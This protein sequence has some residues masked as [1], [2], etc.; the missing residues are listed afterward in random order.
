MSFGPES[1]N[2]PVL[3][4]AEIPLEACRAAL[5]LCSGTEVHVSLY[6]AD[7][8]YVPGMDYWA[9][10]EENNTKVSPQVRAGRGSDGGLGRARHR[11]AQ[12]HA[13]GT[14]RWH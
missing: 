4:T 8:W 1:Q 3:H 7:E 12:G 9:K 6:H 5:E 2:A 14:G 13:H 10:R 11:R